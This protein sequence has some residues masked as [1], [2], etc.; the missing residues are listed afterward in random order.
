MFLIYRAVSHFI[1]FYSDKSFYLSDFERNWHCLH[2]PRIRF[3]K[4]FLNI[5]E[6]ARSSYRRCSIKKVFLKFCEIRLFF[7]KVASLLKKRH[8][9]RCFPV[10]SAK[11]LRI[12]FLQNTSGRL[13]LK[14]RRSVVVLRAITPM[15][16]MYYDY[17]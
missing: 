1:W 4:D 14:R 9:H 17:C 5:S 8:W 12:L 16:I 11:F 6:N 7:N 3:L 2:W 10:N 15:T 13:L